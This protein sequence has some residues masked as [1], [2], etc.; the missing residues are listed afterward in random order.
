MVVRSGLG[1]FR[2]RSVYLNA[3]LAIRLLLYLFLFLRGQLVIHDA[4]SMV[5][6]WLRR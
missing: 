6:N 1:N 4:S 5:S 3:G 2:Q